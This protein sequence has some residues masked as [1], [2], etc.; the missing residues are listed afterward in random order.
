MIADIALMIV[1]YGSAR[2]A[3]AV[4]EPH[5]R[6]TGETWPQVATGLSWIAA[7][8]AIGV[9]VILGI[10]VLHSSASLSDLTN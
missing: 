4:L 7:V 3:T 2:L 10:D 6:G 9:L 8:A 5:R 1:V